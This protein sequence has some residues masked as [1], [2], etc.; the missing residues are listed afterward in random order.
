MSQSI[1][2]IKIIE[3]NPSTKLS[4]PYEGKLIN[5]LKDNFS[6]TEQQL[7]IS[8]FYCYLNYK[9]N[10]FVIDL[11]DIWKWLGYTKKDKGKDLLEKYFKV[12]QDFKK[13]FPDTREYSQA[14]RPKEKIILS[15]KTFKKMCL[16]ANTSKS[17]EIHEYYIKLEEILHEII[18][19]ESN[20]L[21][22]QLEQKDNEIQSIEE[23]NQKIKEAKERLEKRYIKTPRITVNGKNVV[24]LMTSDDGEKKRE[25]AIGKSIDLSNRKYD[26]DCNKIH[27]FKVIYYVSCKSYKIMDLLEAIIISKLNKYK[28]KANRDVLLLPEFNDI[29]LF[30]KVFDE[31]LLYFKDVEP[32][33]IQYATR[34][35]NRTE[36]YED[37][38]EKI[39]EQ[40][41]EFR[42]LNSESI[43]DHRRA[44]HAEN[45][46]LNN[47]KCNLY[48]EEHKEIIKA[49]AID[50]YNENKEVILEERKEFYQ[51][52]KE[53][54][55][56]ERKEYYENNYETKIAPTRQALELCEC[57]MTITNYC[58]KRHKTSASHAR[59]ME[60]KNNPEIIEDESSRTKCECGMVVSTPNL[61]R[62]TNS[63]RHKRLLDKKLEEKKK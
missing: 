40:Q 39:L 47:V 34:T 36:Y 41:Q 9:S 25:Y 11:D 18:D 42:Q 35:Q 20:E 30:T 1:N 8:S 62:H 12:E 29:T 53:A 46:D 43:N 22:R 31:N 26:Y 33:E 49:Q 16:K 3:E 7:F 15:I 23:E 56:E 45:P 50:Y 21:R 48:Y 19:E 57:G 10:D 27:D 55:L 24:Y 37:N 44:K 59:L 63:K 2:I 61:R 28:C 13:I 51:N 58:M 4:K 17:N 52:N 38:R 6:T 5:K 32:D 54:I 14:G 60:K